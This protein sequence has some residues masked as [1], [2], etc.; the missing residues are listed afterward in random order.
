MTPTGILRGYSSGKPT[1]ILINMKLC[2]RT[3]IVL[4]IFTLVGC[5]SST[6]P[7]AQ[8]NRF[9]ACRLSLVKNLDE[10]E[11]SRAKKTYDAQAE[12]NC[13]P[14]LTISEGESK[15]F[16]APALKIQERTSST[17][18][19]TINIEHGPWTIV[20]DS[21][22]N[23]AEAKK[24]C[25]GENFSYPLGEKIE[26]F[27]EDPK[28]IGLGKVSNFVSASYKYKNGEID[29]TCFYRGSLDVTPKGSFYRV[30]IAGTYWNDLT[31]VSS[32]DSANWTLNLK[33]DDY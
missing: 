11:Y 17:K 29:L 25:T 32:L 1:D 16:K 2:S 5:G 3:L 18:K 4:L 12:K 21:P 14:L 6:D 28:I 15:N 27:N 19:L 22:P 24:L 26:I 13:A 7:Q 10:R 23:A 33:S 9:D 8:R 30:K 31:S 20:S